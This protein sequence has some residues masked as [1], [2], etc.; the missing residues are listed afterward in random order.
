LTPGERIV[1]SGAFL[2]D[3]ES[4][5]KPVDSTSKPSAE[6]AK[7]VKDLVCGM[8]VD[9]SPDTLNTRYKGKTYYFCSKQ[10]MKSFEANPEEYIH[11]SMAA[12]A[13]LK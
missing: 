11:K 8:D 7:K 9:R 5:M 13:L 2:I 1:T 12:Q 4:R 3:S 6:K 10:C